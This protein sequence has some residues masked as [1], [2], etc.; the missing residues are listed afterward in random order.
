MGKQEATGNYNVLADRVSSAE[1]NIDQGT[2]IGRI[3]QNIHIDHL[4]INPNTPPEYQ[5]SSTG[6][7]LQQAPSG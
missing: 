4:T 7:P 3:D 1:A 2:H 5:K 6:K